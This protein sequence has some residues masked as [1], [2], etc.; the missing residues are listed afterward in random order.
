MTFYFFPFLIEKNELNYFIFL[1][2]I[3]ILLGI[4]A[5]TNPSPK[6]LSFSFSLPSVAVLPSAFSLL[7]AQL[8]PHPAFCSLEDSH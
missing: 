8:C 5:T 6:P 3:T 4:R 2:V 7:P 1:S